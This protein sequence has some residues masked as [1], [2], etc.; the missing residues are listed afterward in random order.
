MQQAFRGLAQTLTATSLLRQ[1]EWPWVTMPMW[2]VHGKHLRQQSGVE[3]V[4]FSPIITAE[5]RA[6]W[7]AYSQTHQGW[8]D[9]ARVI[10]GNGGEEGYVQGS[11]SPELYNEFGVMPIFPM[12]Y[13]IW[14]LT[15]PP[16]DPAFIN[17]DMANDTFL[18]NLL[19]T[20][21]IAR[22]ALFSD[23]LDLSILSGTAVSAKDHLSFH[24]ILATNLSVDEAYLQ[25]HSLIVQ[26]VFQTLENTSNLV[27]LL[28]G[29]VPWDLYL[30]NLLP[31]GVG[32]ITCVLVNTCD[33]S[34]TY[35]LN[36]NTVSLRWGKVFFAPYSLCSSF[37]L[38]L[39]VSALS[40]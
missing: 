38:T 40:L 3:M 25:P 7:L 14:Q 27:G 35:T 2:E 21:P 19:P 36:G 26:P 20:L 24:D 22:E 8:I 33:Q 37:S 10:S 5:Q 6:E 39:S 18:I 4:G 31:Q 29:V 32:G 30:T 1:W 16:F 17:Y 28:V 11:V 9:E 15:P 13:P 12:H 34:F 23:V